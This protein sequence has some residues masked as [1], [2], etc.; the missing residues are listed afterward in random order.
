MFHLMLVMRGKFLYGLT[1]ES[2]HT[3]HVPGAGV[4][5]A[6]FKSMLSDADPASA[7]ARV[8]GRVIDALPGES[9]WE[10]LAWERY[11]RLANRAFRQSHMG[12]AAVIA[13]TALR[14]VEAANLIT[15]S[16]G[17]RA[18]MPATQVRARM[19]PRTDVE[20]THA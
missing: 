9:A 6:R 16:E 4:S 3:F 13:Y 12:L 7:L 11:H 14:R 10:S 2:L 8:V 19:I 18:G 17:I 1:A 20:R 5:P 15:L